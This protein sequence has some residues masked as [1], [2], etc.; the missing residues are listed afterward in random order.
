M[1]RLF[2][3]CAAGA[4]LVSALAVA[5]CATTGGSPAASAPASTTAAAPVAASADWK[6]VAKSD[7]QDVFVDDASIRERDGFIE[8]VTRYEYAQPQPY[9]KKTFRSARNV[10]RFDC[11]NRRIA[12]RENLV[13][14]E[15]QLGGAKV[16]DAT[17]STAN[18]I[19]RDAVR[20]TADG[21]VLYYVCSKS[22]RAP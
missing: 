22:G 2:G 20:G 8:A 9:G 13:Y 12:D 18:L 5:G 4:V 14:A 7:N 10:Y 15:P 3:P 16:G 1:N 19:W 21:A 17:R 11:A 6:S